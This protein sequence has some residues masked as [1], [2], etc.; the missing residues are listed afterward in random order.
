MASSLTFQSRRAPGKINHVTTTK[1]AGIM[2]V[3]QLSATCRVDGPASVCATVA[4]SAAVVAQENSSPVRPHFEFRLE[5]TSASGIRNFQGKQVFI[6]SAPSEVCATPLSHLQVCPQPINFS[7]KEFPSQLWGIT[8]VEL[9]QAL[10][11]PVF[12][13][14]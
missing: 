5:S 3:S 12:G 4:M 11:Y 6:M 14:I 9:Q 2:Q 7:H 13:A 10:R 1:S 8:A